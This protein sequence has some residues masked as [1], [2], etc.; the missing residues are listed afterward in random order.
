MNIK[1]LRKDEL[2]LLNRNLKRENVELR[3]RINKLI[4]EEKRR[5][6][7]KEYDKEYYRKKK[8]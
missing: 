5:K 3:A 1:I 4:G 2:I 7:K 6:Y 8:K